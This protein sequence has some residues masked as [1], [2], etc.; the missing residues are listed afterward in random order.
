MKRPRFLS[1]TIYRSQMM[2]Y[3]LAT[4]ILSFMSGTSVSNA[5]VGMTQ[6][7]IFTTTDLG[8]VNE[9][10]FSPKELH[11][12][13]DIQFYQLNGIQLIETELSRGLTANPDL[14]KHYA[15]QHIHMLDD[16]ARARMQ[17]SAIGLAM[18]LQY[19]IDRYPAIVFDGQAVIYG[20]TDLNAALAHYQ[21]WR[22]EVKP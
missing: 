14:S 5:T 9:P 20:V 4:L 6:V 1:P 3:V 8:I 7:E 12:N 18:A 21:T 11:R 16:Q 22:T 2:Y 13:I 10:A 19:G 17:H 15:L